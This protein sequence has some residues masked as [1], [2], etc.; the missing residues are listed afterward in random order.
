MSKIKLG[1]APKT[2]KSKVS[3]PMID[4]SDATIEMVFKYRTKTQYGALVDDLMS[5]A[6]KASKSKDKTIEGAF[7][8][9]I[10]NNVDFVLKIA[11][12]WDL[13]DEFNAENIALLDDEYQ[14]AITA[15]GEAYRSALVEGRAKN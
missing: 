13:D 7:K 15:I 12:G 5:T 9:A 2:F 6:E 4:G 8:S 1:Q 3:I 11:E 10:D 14:G